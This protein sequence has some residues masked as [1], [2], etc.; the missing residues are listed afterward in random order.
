MFAKFVSLGSWDYPEIIGSEM[1]FLECSKRRG[2]PYR[3]FAV[4][5]LACRPTGVKLRAIRFLSFDMQFSNKL[6]LVF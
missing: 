2:V 6:Q 1:M 5:A 3:T 4:G